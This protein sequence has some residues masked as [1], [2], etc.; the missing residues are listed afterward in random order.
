MSAI[1]REKEWLKE[2]IVEEGKTRLKQHNNYGWTLENYLH[3]L[4]IKWSVVNGVV[5]WEDLNNY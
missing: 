1:K 2:T 4:E 5:L 3:M